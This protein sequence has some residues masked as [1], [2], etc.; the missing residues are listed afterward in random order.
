[1]SKIKK[2]RFVASDLNVNKNNNENKY[3]YIND[4]LTANN[5]RLLWMAKIKA[6]ECGWKFVWIRNG[7]IFAKKSETTSVIHISNNADIEIITQII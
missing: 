4:E 5:M 3:I 6:K 1:M 2:R 7:H